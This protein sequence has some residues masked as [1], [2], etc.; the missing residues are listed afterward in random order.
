MRSAS[1]PDLKLSATADN[2]RTGARAR[3]A[4]PSQRMRADTLP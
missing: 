2:D 4:S 1:H 3:L